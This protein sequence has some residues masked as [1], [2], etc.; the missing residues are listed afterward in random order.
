[1]IQEKDRSA[2]TVVLILYVLIFLFAAVG[3]QAADQAVLRITA[4]V[5]HSLEIEVIPDKDLA[6]FDLTGKQDMLKVGEVEE[7][8]N[9]RN[10]YQVILE[11]EN[12][13]SRGQ[14]IP[15]LQGE[16]PDNNLGVAYEL[17]YDGR[18]IVFD[19][20]GRA[21]VTDAITDTTASGISRNVYISYDGTDA[22]LVSDYYSDTLTFSITPK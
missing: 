16:D 8:A 5:G 4:T 13:R 11:S 2:G 22:E 6:L 18:K 3:L 19:L 7:R 1:M 12:A 15:F 9:V 21:I 10:G 20:D 17:Y 14:G